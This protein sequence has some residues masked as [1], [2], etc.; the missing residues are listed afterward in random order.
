MGSMDLLNNLK[1]RIDFLLLARFLPSEVLGVYGAVAE[2][3]SVLR[4]SRAAF[5]PIMMPI[6]QRLHITHEHAGLQRETTRAVGWALQLGLGMLGVKANMPKAL[7][8]LDRRGD[9]E[10]ESGA[11]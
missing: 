4:K 5:D 1:T 11:E 9:V 10:G 8:G 7:W 2:I 3:A 6:A